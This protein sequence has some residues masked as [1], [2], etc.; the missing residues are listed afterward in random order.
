MRIIKKILRIIAI[1]LPVFCGVVLPKSVSAARYAIT[2]LPLYEPI[3][4]DTGI[5]GLV[6]SPYSWQIKGG[7]PLRQTVNFRN[8]EDNQCVQTSGNYIYTVGDTTMIQFPAWPHDDSHANPC[9]L[10]NGTWYEYSSV[11]IEDYNLRADEDATSISYG[12]QTVNSKFKVVEGRGFDLVSLLP[13]LFREHNSK[14]FQIPFYY[15]PISMDPIHTD[16]SPTNDYQP[17]IHFTL[18]AAANNTVSLNVNKNIKLKFNYFDTSANGYVSDYSTCHA[19]S[20]TGENATWLE[21]DCNLPFISE[22]GPDFS[23]GKPVFFAIEFEEGAIYSSNDKLYFTNFYFQ[24]DT[25]GKIEGSWS[26][27]Q[28]GN[29]VSA[30]PKGILDQEDLNFFRMFNFDLLNPFSVLFNQFSHPDECVD[31]PIIAGA[32]HLPY[33]HICSIYPSSLINL[34]TPVFSIIGTVMITGYFIKW[35]RD[36]DGVVVNVKGGK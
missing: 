18:T 19:Y 26:L 27:V 6:S 10:L 12:D 36:D 33:S 2:D 34:T 11:H 9:R 30:A 24:S 20:Y 31:I 35:L 28:S 25:N 21:I 13:D 16:E 8:Y 4:Y 5:P 3:Y 23:L 29:N 22:T 7:T 1:L 32:I 15:D 14:F 17:S